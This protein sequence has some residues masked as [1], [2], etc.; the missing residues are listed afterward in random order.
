M[1]GKTTLYVSFRTKKYSKSDEFVKKI[2]NNLF[3]TYCVLISN[4]F[5]WQVWPIEFFTAAKFPFYIKKPFSVFLE[6]TLVR[7]WASKSLLYL[8]ILWS[9]SNCFFA[10]ECSFRWFLKLVWWSFVYVPLHLF[11]IKACW[12]ISFKE[13][14][15]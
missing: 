6:F 13:Y 11:A 12:T 7:V 4:S 5:L 15:T 8:W 14:V 10:A 9:S 3:T 1:S 2:N